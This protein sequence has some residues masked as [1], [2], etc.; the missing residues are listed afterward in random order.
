MNWKLW[1]FPQVMISLILERLG[2]TS[3]TSGE[4]GWMAIGC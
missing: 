4:L 3:P 2:G 1:S